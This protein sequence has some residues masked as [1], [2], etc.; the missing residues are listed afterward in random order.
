VAK[1][2]ILTLIFVIFSAS[3][4]ADDA[5]RRLMPPSLV[6]A[7]VK[8]FGDFHPPLATNNTAEDIKWLI[9]RGGSGCFGAAS[10]DFDGDGRKDFILRLTAKD[11]DKGAVVVAFAKKQGW[12][13]EKLAD[14]SGLNGLRL[15]VDVASPGTYELSRALG[16]PGPND[17][18]PLKCS[19]AAAMFG[20]IEA[21][22][23]T[24]CYNEGKWQRVQTSD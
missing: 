13:F 3:A 12:T 2:K 4:V 24:Y 14:A 8:A 5:C 23:I 18:T 10:A 22:D 11:G 19:N 7:T 1:L 17:T 6:G 9:N 15:F 20:Q 21:W 16:S